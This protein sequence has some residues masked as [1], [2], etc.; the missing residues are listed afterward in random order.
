MYGLPE[1]TEV[2]KL[3]SKNKLFN[4]CGFNSKN[5]DIVNQYISKIKITNELNSRS[6][7]VLESEN[8]SSIFVVTV[9]L[10]TRECNMGAINLLAKAIRQ[11][12]IMVLVY[13]DICRLAIFHAKLFIND[14][15]PLD[16]CKITIK[17]NSLDSVW[18]NLVCDIGGFR[19]NANNT[20]D[21]QISLN[22]KRDELMAKIDK[23][24]IRK[25]K[26]TQPNK[27]YKLHE[28]IKEFKHRLENL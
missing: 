10:K 13:G 7:N 21:D 15:I 24:E 12:L 26:E 6:I 3:L 20:L 9:E 27:K 18:K 1:N 16:E 8:L 23:L 28:E 2:N 22:E 14:W 19:V 25:K 17:G 5:K 4:S 11:H